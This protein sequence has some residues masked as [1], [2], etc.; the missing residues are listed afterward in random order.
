MPPKRKTSLAPA[1]VY[2][3]AFCDRCAADGISVPNPD[4]QWLKLRHLTGPDYSTAAAKREAAAA[5]S[6][7]RANASVGTD[8]LVFA[9]WSSLP[10][11]EASYVRTVTANQYRAPHDTEDVACAK[12]VMIMDGLPAAVFPPAAAPRHNLAPI[13]SPPRSCCS[14]SSARSPTDSSRQSL[15]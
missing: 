12:L 4:A 13:R 15:A 10:I 5:W 7:A 6:W 1:A 2:S 3:R 8:G 9:D 11:P 14:G